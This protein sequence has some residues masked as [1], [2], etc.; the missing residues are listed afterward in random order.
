MKKIILIS[1]INCVAIIA[2]AQ[3]IEKNVIGSAGKT[4]TAGNIQLDFTVGEAFA[5]SLTTSSGNITQGFHQP[6]L[7]ITRFADPEDTTN[8]LPAER[9]NEK[10][11]SGIDLTVY[12]NPA[13]D[14]INLKLNHAID[15]SLT[16]TITNMQGQLVKQ[17]IMQQQTMKI[18]FSN[19]VAG[20]YLVIV[21]NAKGDL[22]NT[23]KVVKTN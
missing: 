18:D 12:P 13:V 19:L 20:T 6:A 4:L 8:I 16:I 9:L 21:K 7:T 10:L 23:Y 2:N 11:I 5:K 22:N 14:F 3:S 1:A 17:E 15:E